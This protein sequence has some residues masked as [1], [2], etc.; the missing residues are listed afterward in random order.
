MRQLVELAEAVLGRPSELWSQEALERISHQSVPDIMLGL[1]PHV[2][3]GDINALWITW[4]LEAVFGPP[5]LTRL[6]FGE[7][8]EKAHDAL[9]TMLS[10]SPLDERREVAKKLASLARRDIRRRE[11]AERRAWTLDEKRQLLVDSGPNPRCWVCGFSFSSVA[12]ERFLGNLGAESI[13]SRPLFLDVFRPAGAAERD[14][15]I[16]I[17]HR[18]PVTHGGSDGDN[19]GLLCGWCNRHKRD[20]RFIYDGSAFVRELAHPVRGAIGVPQP[21]WVVRTVSLRPRCEFT[22]GCDRHA[23]NSQLTVALL[24]EAGSANPTNLW[25]CCPEHDPHLGWRFVPREGF[26]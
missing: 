21:F 24:N 5:G 9:Q 12:V 8:Y 7:L 18:H 22:D 13:V 23:G 16:E 14:L 25:V 19:L 17:D 26:A 1:H 2:M 10:R 3:R 20:N 15:L 4:F 11:D 6:G